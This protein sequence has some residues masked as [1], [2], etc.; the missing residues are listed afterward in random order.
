M[1]EQRACEAQDF[2]NAPCWEIVS[3]SVVSCD[4]LR[5]WVSFSR[6]LMLGQSGVLVIPR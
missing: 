1:I 4:C 3:R 6:L 2:G 5:A